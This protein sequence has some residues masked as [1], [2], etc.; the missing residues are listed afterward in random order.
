MAAVE[1]VAKVESRLGYD[2]DDTE[3]LVPAADPPEG[4][5]VWLDL[6]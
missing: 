6:G 1:G 2:F 3:A 4:H 5:S